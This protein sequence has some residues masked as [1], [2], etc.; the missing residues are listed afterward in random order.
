MRATVL[1]VII[2]FIAYPAGIKDS[3][4]LAFSY[5][6]LVQRHAWWTLITALLIHG[7]LL[8]LLGNMLFLLLFGNA[9][10]REIGPGRLLV[11][12]F[13]GGIIS[14][15]CSFFFYNPNEQIVGASGS[16]CTIIGL[17]MIYNPWK[18]SFLL[19]FFPMPMGVAALT[20]LAVNFFMAFSPQNTDGPHTAYQL[21]IVG[22]LVGIAFGVLWNEDWKK[23]LLISILSF[24]GFYIIL[25]VLLYYLGH[26]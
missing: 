8:H 13:A 3:D 17:L 23:N 11:C 19:N 10:E 1:L 15:L 18:I 12:F 26:R 24:I 2:C 4:L 16:I 20:Y 6:S 9:L 25:G 7:S 21:H 5:A 22:F 14:L